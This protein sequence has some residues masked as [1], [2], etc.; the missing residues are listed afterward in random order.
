MDTGRSLSGVLEEGG[1]VRYEFSITTQ[2]LVFDVCISQGQVQLYGS[3]TVPNPNS[4]LNDLSLSLN[5]SSLCSNI[6][7][8]GNTVDSNETTPLHDSF[9]VL[10]EGTEALN[11]FNIIV[12]ATEV[13]IDNQDINRG[14]S[15]DEG[16][17]E[18]D[19]QVPRYGKIST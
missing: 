5:S 6:T 1:I 7:I 12:P 3:Y 16:S 15:S 14:S 11:A 19:V 18:H 4:A 17:G 13:P 2:D 8:D 9:F 10:L